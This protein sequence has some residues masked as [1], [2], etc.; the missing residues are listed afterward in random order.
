MPKDMAAKM[1][2]RAQKSSEGS[3]HQDFY[4]SADEDEKEHNSKHAWKSS[5]CLVCARSLQRVKVGGKAVY[6]T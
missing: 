2:K 6:R 3:S 5:R 1:R 4:M